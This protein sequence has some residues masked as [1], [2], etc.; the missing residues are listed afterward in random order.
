MVRG[1][2][3]S[4]DLQIKSGR[5]KAKAHLAGKLHFDSLR[6]IKMSLSKVFWPE[7][8]QP[9]CSAKLHQRSTP[10]SFPGVAV[11]KI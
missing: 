2:K 9:C 4:T 8:K 10:G 7:W 3:T 1:R 6:Q 11:D 5:I